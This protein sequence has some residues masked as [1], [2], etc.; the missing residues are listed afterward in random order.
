MNKEIKTHIKNKS[1]GIKDFNKTQ[2]KY[3]NYKPL[4]V[5]E[6]F[7]NNDFENFLEWLGDRVES[8]FYN[9]SYG[10]SLLSQNKKSCVNMVK[11]IINNITKNINQDYIKSLKPNSNKNEVRVLSIIF[12]LKFYN[13]INEEMKTA[14]LSLYGL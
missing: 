14:L 9:Y 2:Q 5:E 8:E 6:F 4:V 11:T 13:K 12:Y 10:V 7:K 1:F 3:Y